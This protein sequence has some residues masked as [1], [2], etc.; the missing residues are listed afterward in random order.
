ML[1]RLNTILG[2]HQ[3]VVHAITS[4]TEDLFI[5]FFYLLEIFLISYILIIYLENFVGY[6]TRFIL[7]ANG[8]FLI[9]FCHLKYS[10]DSFLFYRGIPSLKQ[11]NVNA[12]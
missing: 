12:T 7:L 9:G 3:C 1:E 10:H 11:L 2:S 8:T 4:S 6:N 5:N